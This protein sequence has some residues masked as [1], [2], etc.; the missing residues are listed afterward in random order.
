LVGRS[1]P[2]VGVEEERKEKK[3]EKEMLL[4]ST[5][6]CC[7]QHMSINLN[8]LLRGYVFLQRENQSR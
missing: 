5:K 3:R 1:Q 2:S 8:K 6:V 4:P 7:F